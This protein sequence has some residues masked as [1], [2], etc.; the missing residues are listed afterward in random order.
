VSLERKD[1]RVKFDAP[2][3]AALAEFADLDG[4]DIAEWVEREVVRLIRA[5]AHSASLVAER[6]RRLGIS[7]ERRASA[8]F[9][10]SLGERA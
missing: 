9:S 8:G 7:W 10:G 5:R 6:M 2:M 4:L 1:V 3:H